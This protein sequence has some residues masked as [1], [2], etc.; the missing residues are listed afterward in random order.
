MLLRT[1]W[2]KYAWVVECIYNRALMWGAV[3][4]V[5]EPRINS[6]VVY[7]HLRGC[8]LRM[9]SK[10]FRII[11]YVNSQG[12][13]VLEEVVS[14]FFAVTTNWTFPFFFFFSLIACLCDGRLAKNKTTTGPYVCMF[15]CLFLS[16]KPTRWEGMMDTHEHIHI[17]SHAG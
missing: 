3:C 5:W 6:V 12:R 7:A 16:N 9:T 17:L 1:V 4:N 11:H 15:V 2:G 10:L 14:V 13:I 8:A